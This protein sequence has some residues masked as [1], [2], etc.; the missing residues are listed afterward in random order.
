MNKHIVW[1]LIRNKHIDW[2]NYIIMHYMILLV[3]YLQNKSQFRYKIYTKRY[4]KDTK[5]SH[6]KYNYRHSTES[7]KNIAK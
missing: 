5:R 3:V 4:I 6:G 2:N 7:T 1:K